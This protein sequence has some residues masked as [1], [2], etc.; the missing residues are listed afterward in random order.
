ML[1]FPV[2]S[3]DSVFETKPI[4]TKVPVKVAPALVIPTSY[5]AVTTTTAPEAPVAVPTRQTQSQ[6]TA[7]PQ[8]PEPLPA[9]A[10]PTSNGEPTGD[11]RNI[12][13]NRAG[14]RV[15]RFMR[16]PTTQEKERFEARIS[17]RK[18]CNEY[19]LRHA[20]RQPYCRYDHDPVDKELLYTLRYTARR[21]PCP[22]GMKCRRQDCYLGHHCP[23]RE[24]MNPKCHF[25]KNGLHDV[26][27]LQ[28]A[29]FVQ[30]E[31]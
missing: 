29:K 16:E 9:L 20:C 12:P 8:R 2:V 17:Y 26:I 4:P 19:H 30:A 23:W 1:P 10:P 24:C 28:V 11:P 3:I 15:D 5:A 27:D 7:V 18:L 21:I 13:I 14:Q 22:F 25:L 6:P 31:S